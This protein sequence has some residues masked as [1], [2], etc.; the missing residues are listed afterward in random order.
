M[1]VLFSASVL[2]GSEEEGREGELTCSL[3]FARLNK[4]AKSTATAVVRKVITPTIV[5]TLM[6]CVSLSLSLSLVA[7]DRRRGGGG[8]AELTLIFTLSSFACLPPFPRRRVRPCARA[9][10]TARKPRWQRTSS[11]STTSVLGAATEEG[12]AQRASP[13]R[14][15][16]ER[17]RRRGREICCSSDALLT[18]DLGVAEGERFLAANWREKERRGPAKGELESCREAD[19]LRVAQD[20]QIQVL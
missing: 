6:S 11:P 2:R 15:G 3:R 14:A 12:S 5:Q 18:W 7:R 20:S 4:Q 17:W 13:R 10:H 16:G 1:F 9:Y 8:S 19:S